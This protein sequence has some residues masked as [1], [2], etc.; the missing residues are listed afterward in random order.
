MDVEEGI[1][2]SRIYGQNLTQKKHQGRVT[3]YL[4]FLLEVFHLGMDDG[5][6]Q[7]RSIPKS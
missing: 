6:V 2:V 7:K 4:L 1:E 5:G 3:L